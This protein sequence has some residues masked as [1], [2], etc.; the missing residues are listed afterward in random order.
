MFLA[1]TSTHSRH[2]PTTTT[3]TLIT[4]CATYSVRENE[5]HTT[6][7][8]AP[9]HTIR[10]GEI[11]QWRHKNGLWWWLVVGCRLSGSVSLSGITD[12]HL[13]KANWE[14]SYIFGNKCTNRIPTYSKIFP[15]CCDY[16]VNGMEM[17][18]AQFFSWMRFFS[19]RFFTRKFQANRTQYWKIT[20]IINTFAKKKKK[21]IV[22][23]ANEFD[24][25]TIYAMRHR[26]E[27]EI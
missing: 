11:R 16:F 1:S 7:T 13:V 3:Y 8:S 25:P 14:I 23:H 12:T 9:T 27:R 5:K 17:L 21:R 22:A 4:C 19:I 20:L 10:I 24:T 2:H 6:K 26:V 15:R 18:L